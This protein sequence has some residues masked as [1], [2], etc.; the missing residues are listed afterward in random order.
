MNVFIIPSW[1]PSQQHQLPGRFFRDQ[2]KMYANQF[3]EDRIGIGHWG[4]HDDR[5]L[6]EMKKIH[7]WPK[8]LRQGQSLSSYSKALSPNLTEHF[9]P[10][11]T[12][13]RRFLKGNIRGITEAVRTS[14]GQFEKDYEKP[15][16]LHAH[17]GYPGGYVARM[18]SKQLGLPYIIS[19]HMGPFPF[20]A[21]L[22]GKRVSSHLLG[23]LKG[24]TKVLAVSKNLQQELGRQGVESELFHNFI[25]EE[26]FI[27]SV[28]KRNQKFTLLHLGRLE[29]E[30][31]Q[32]TLIRSIAD[33]E[34]LD[35][36]LIIAGEGSLRNKLV[37]ET[38]TLGLKSKVFFLGEVDAQ[39]ARRLIAQCNV[40]VLSSRYE[41][42]P[43]SIME[44]LASG[45]PVIA[46]T[47]GG[48][49]E[50]LREGNG[51]L[52]PPGDVHAFAKAIHF[53]YSNHQQ[54]SSIQIREDFIAR[55]GKD[56]ALE[57]LRDHY[58]DVLRIWESGSR[59][60]G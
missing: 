23:P 37:H 7:L 58:L 15:D 43:V 16:L 48:S 8:K 52:V 2:A 50:M 56:R 13:S 30:K 54:F 44:A 27:P 25:D 33:V 26:F 38:E 46:T 10:A 40:F 12:W 31:D 24:A 5:L 60:N 9:S 19:E 35:L 47:C 34:K 22:N 17:V 39:Q 42:F 53:M 11:F 1:Y 32:L 45:K 29:P 49:S 3:P 21:F 18:L 59:P 36:E 41:N 51:I 55:F 6:L 57:Q 4:S 20:P 28:D 14:L